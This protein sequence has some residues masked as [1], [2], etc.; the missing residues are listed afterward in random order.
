[1]A[2][3]PVAV[4]D[5]KVVPMQSAATTSFVPAVV[6]GGKEVL[7][8][9]AQS[10]I[11]KL[12]AQLRKSS[13]FLDYGQDVSI[14]LS[15]YADKMLEQV[16]LVSA[17]D[18]TKPLTD[19]LQICA[20]VNSKS[21]MTGKAGRLPFVQRIKQIF[22]SQKVKAMSQFNSVKGQIDDIIKG[23]D[24]KEKTFRNLIKMLEDLYVLNMNDYYMLEAHIRAAEEFKSEKE[25]EYTT[26]LANNKEE[27]QSNPLLAQ[28]ANDIQR[29]VTKV[30]RKLY[31]LRAIQMSCVQFAP[32]LRREQDSSERLI[33]KFNSIKTFA[34]PLWKKQCAA[35]ITSLENKS[36][37][38]LANAADATTNTLYRTHMDT[39]NKNALDTAKSLEAGIISM[40]TL[41]YANTALVQSIQD[42]LQVVE[43]GNK[44]RA[45]AIPKFQSMQQEIYTRVINPVSV[46]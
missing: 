41:E 32:Q 21:L 12:K 27:M 19:V 14:K 40:D 45:E 16:A 9:Q 26:F 36:G 3:K 8:V 23:V 38:A 13:D 30:D 1:M 28:Q 24:T 5:I 6:K 44:Q 37:V 34:I 25:A 2:F 15:S 42:V 20:G 18:F 39:V 17:D 22:A 10:E 35:Y 43:E 4:Q 7:P 46:R 31:D 11:P 29:V 33:E